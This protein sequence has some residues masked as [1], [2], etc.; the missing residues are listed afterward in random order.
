[1][2]GI[3]T[4]D[5]SLT[6][7]QARALKT[8]WQEKMTGVS[9]AHEVAVLDQNIKFQQLTIPPEDAQFLESRQFSVEEVCRL[10]GVPPYLA[11][12]VDKTT[13]WGAGI[14]EQSLGF[15]RYTISSWTDRYER[16]IDKHLLPPGF[17][18]EFDA[19]QLLRGDM[20]ARFG[21]Y[22]VGMSAG[23]LNGNTVRGWEGLPPEAGLDE[24]KP[25]PDT[26]PA[27]PPAGK[28]PKGS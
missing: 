21:A 24:Y 27:M 19:S 10:F 7:D 16:R 18:C 20:A 14:A 15:H 23:F 22:A 8:R 26:P 5:Q 4:T 17:Y 28:D 12:Q 25:I 11:M 3:L 13:S 1:M 6:E 9:K 2:G